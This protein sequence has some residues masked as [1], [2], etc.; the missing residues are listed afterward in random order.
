MSIVGN[1]QISGS[2][3]VSGSIVVSGSKTILASRF[4]G[5]HS[6]SFSGSFEGDGSNLTGVNSGSFSGSFIGDGSQLTNTSWSGQ[7]TGSAG[8]SGSLEIDGRVNQV[9]LGSSTFFGN[10]AGENDDKTNNSNTAFGDGAFRSNAEGTKNTAVGASALGVNANGSDNT[11]LGY[12]ALGSNDGTSNT[13]IGSNALSFDNNGD[14]NVAIGIHASLYNTDGDGNT[15]VGS[16]ASAYNLTG[17]NNTALGYRAGYYNTGSGE[18]NVFLG[19]WAGPLSGSSVSNKLYI[20]NNSGSALIQGDFSTSSVTINGSIT[21]SG[22]ISGS[23]NTIFSGQTFSAHGNSGNSGLTFESLHEKPTISASN[24]ILSIGTSHSGSNHIGTRFNQAVTASSH[25]SAS[26]DITAASFIGKSDAEITGSLGVTED[27]TVGSQIVVGT[28]SGT[29]NPVI[30]SL[31]SNTSENILLESSDTGVGSA[32]DLV[33][34]RNAGIPQDDDTLG[35]VEYKTNNLSGN[36]P[37]VWNGIYSRVIDASQQQSALTISAFYGSSTANGIGV[38]NIGDSTSTGAVIISPNTFNQVPQH[39]LD[40]QGDARVT[41]DLTITGSIVGLSKLTVGSSQLNTG[42]LSTI[43]GGTGNIINVHPCSFI[44]GGAGNQIAGNNSVIGG[45]CNN[46]SGQYS[47]VGSGKDN[48]VN[49]SFSVIGGGTLNTGSGACGF[50]GGG[51]SNYNEQIYGAIGGGYCNKIY[52]P[53]DSSTIVGGHSNVISGSGNSVI[54]GYGNTIDAGSENW[55][56]AGGSIN[57]SGSQSIGSTNFAAQNI[58]I[59]GSTTTNGILVLSRRETTP[60]AR[61]GMIIASGSAGSSKLYYYNGTS[62]NALF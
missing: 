32:P 51:E 59:T 15:A 23:V 53:N 28:S 57:I 60:S 19:A 62:W 22:D 10:N 18:K 25:I 31:V 17:D 13:A 35:V 29:Q 36:S 30:H 5:T 11:A 41:T 44:G 37:F 39:T 21:A 52:G 27:L 6:G 54:L 34:F 4:D 49:S 2:L 56:V 26:G 40:V 58:H 8:I 46:Y 33:L 48:C 43:G 12:N 14:K 45:G 47:F 24:G 9:G 42:T 3:T 61:E 38:H 16:E 55:I 50:I 7:F 20:N 1:L